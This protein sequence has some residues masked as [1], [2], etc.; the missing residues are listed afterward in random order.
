M[1]DLTRPKPAPRRKRTLDH[2]ELRAFWAVVSEFDWPFGPFYRLLLLT[3]ARREE[4][5]GMRRSEVFFDRK[6]WHLPSAE[7]FQPQRTKN[8]QEHIIDLSPQTIS[9]L[10]SLPRLQGDFVF[11]TTGRTPISGFGKAKARLDAVMARRL[12]KPIRPWR[13]HDIRR[14][15]ASLMGD[16]LDIDQGV[17]ERCLNHLTGTQ[18]GLMGTYQR[19][20]Y[21]AKRQHAMVAWGAHV[22]RICEAANLECL[23]QCPGGKIRT[24]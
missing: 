2:E 18:S 17:I 15:V 1:S 9:V 5:A 13:V 11:S 7:E 20:Q 23:T 22:A 4:V 12:D 8:G 19:Q 16:D 14:T 21:R 24:Q 10:E 3:G 6:V